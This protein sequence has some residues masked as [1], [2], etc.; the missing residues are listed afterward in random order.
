MFSK[1][2]WKV[3]FIKWD[4]D[5]CLNLGAAQQ[6][7]TIRGIG[8]TPLKQSVSPYFVSDHNLVWGPGL[9]STH[10][11]HFLPFPMALATAV[12]SE[13]RDA[14]KQ[15]IWGKKPY[16]ANKPQQKYCTQRFQIDS[17]YPLQPKI[18]QLQNCKILLRFPYATKPSDLYQDVH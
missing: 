9:S 4:S 17:T 1:C 14:E 11:G 3:T 7:S 13:K 18:K 12:C 2:I 6:T 5:K 16:P 15:V 10:C 8:Q